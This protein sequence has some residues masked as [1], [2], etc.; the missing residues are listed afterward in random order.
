MWERIGRRNAKR[1][2]AAVSLSGALGRVGDCSGARRPSTHES[3]TEGLWGW[4]F[5]V[6]W[7]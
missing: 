1:S 2:G 3:L 5:L 4:V 7:P 6:P